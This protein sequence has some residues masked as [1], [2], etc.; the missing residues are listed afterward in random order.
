MTVSSPSRMYVQFDPRVGVPR[1][2]FASWGTSPNNHCNIA[3]YRPV[4][5]SEPL[6]FCHIVFR[7]T[8]A[9]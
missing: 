7:V 2:Q 5:L 4:D 9:R 3:F 1:H 6:D 8:L